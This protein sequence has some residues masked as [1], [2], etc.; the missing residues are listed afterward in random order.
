M[1][2]SLTPPQTNTNRHQPKRQGKGR[3]RGG[4]SAKGRLFQIKKEVRE[5]STEVFG[6]EPERAP[7]TIMAKSMS[8]SSFAQWEQKKKMR[9]LRENVGV[10]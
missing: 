9:Q 1:H 4:G 7:G 8:A 3:G 6:R 2:M 5:G 10:P